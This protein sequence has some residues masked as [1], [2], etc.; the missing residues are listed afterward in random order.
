MMRLFIDLFLF[1]G[2]FFFAFLGWC[3]LRAA[4]NTSRWE[5]RN[6]PPTAGAV[7]EDNVVRIDS[8]PRRSSGNAHQRRIQRRAE[9]RAHKLAT[10]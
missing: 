7:N 1:G 2:L 5:E 8:R 4:G 3:L 10:A 9:E 6:L